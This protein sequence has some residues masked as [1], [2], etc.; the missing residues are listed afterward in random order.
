MGSR[1]GKTCPGDIIVGYLSK[2]G[3]TKHGAPLC[4]ARFRDLINEA[5]ADHP[6]H[7]ELLDFTRYR[8]Q[9]R[10]MST[11]ADVEGN[12]KSQVSGFAAVAFCS[13]LIETFECYEYGLPGSNTNLWPRKSSAKP[14]SPLESARKR[15]VARACDVRC[16]LLKHLQ[17]TLDKPPTEALRLGQTLYGRF[18]QRH[19]VSFVDGHGGDYGIR[20]YKDVR[21]GLLHQGET[22]GDWLISLTEQAKRIDSKTKKEF[23]AVPAKELVRHLFTVTNEFLD[24]ANIPGEHHSNLIDK[25]RFVEWQSDHGSE[26]NQ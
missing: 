16:D 3:D 19:P 2:E 14:E 18:F 23:T 25:L 21:C 20:F 13:I 7:Q 8:I 1:N 24:S 4:L 17:E 6:M 15:A 10:F 26:E 22:K 9:R 11:I 12:L 5:A